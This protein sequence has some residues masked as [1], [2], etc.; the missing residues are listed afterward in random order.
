MATANN[1][2][3]EKSGNGKSSVPAG[4]AAANPLLSL[5]NE[6]D[7]L[8][9]DFFRGWPS[10]SSVSSRMLDF[11]PFRRTAE[12]FGAGLGALLP[13][14]DV[15]ESAE[16]Y[17]IEAELPGMDEK[18]VSLTCSDGVLTIRGEKKAE[19]EEK[20]KDY[21]LSERSYGTVQRSF[22]LPDNVDEAKIA[23]TFEKGVLSISLPKSKEAKA[24]ERKISITSK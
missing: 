11:A 12:P 1:P 18:D 7:R 17:R 3:T 24:S 10:L 2:A 13:K 23:A 22:E 16:A 14:V 6:V 5:R 9:D 4:G 21:Y 8:F 20:K 19:R 15:S